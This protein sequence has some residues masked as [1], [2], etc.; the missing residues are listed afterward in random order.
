M[1]L[2]KYLKMCPHDR[3]PIGTHRENL[4]GIDTRR[5][6]KEE[7]K[8]LPCLMTGSKNKQR[9]SAPYFRAGILNVGREYDFPGSPNHLLL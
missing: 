6:G 4:L 8:A 7:M 1:R 5:S 9:E 2:G 3:F